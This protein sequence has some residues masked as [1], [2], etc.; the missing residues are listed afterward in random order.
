[1]PLHGEAWRRR[2]GNPPGENQVRL[3]CRH[4]KAQ[5]LSRTFRGRRPFT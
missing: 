1:M 5:G 3:D 4:G 2:P